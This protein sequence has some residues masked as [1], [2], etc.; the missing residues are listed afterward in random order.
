MEHINVIYSIKITTLLKMRKIK[1]RCIMY[2]TGK[3][4]TVPP[5]DFSR[6][7]KTLKIHNDTYSFVTPEHQGKIE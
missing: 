3:N 6:L 4:K 7:W 5:W 2:L 1:L